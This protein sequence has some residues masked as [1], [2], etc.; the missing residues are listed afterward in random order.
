MR[1]RVIPA[2]DLLGEELSRVR[3]RAS[4][5]PRVIPADDAILNAIPLD[6]VLELQ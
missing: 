6:S 4:M 2:D 5:R 1:P 3:G